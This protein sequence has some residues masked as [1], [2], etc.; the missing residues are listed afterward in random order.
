MSENYS[1]RSAMNGF[2]RNDVIIYIDGVLAEKARAEEKVA[3]LEKEL[4]SLR[5]ENE[6]L[7]K[8]ID[9]ENEKKSNNEK[10]SECDVSKVYEARLGA[11]MLDA[12]RFSEI[13]VKEANDKASGIFSNAYASADA[14]STKAKSIS[15][16]ISDINNQF[17]LAFKVLLDNMNSLG[18][19][20]DLFKREVQQTG[21]KFDFLTDFVPVE[22]D[23]HLKHTIETVVPQI[24]SSDVNF[25]DAD[26]FDIRVDIND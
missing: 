25:D 17:N 7:K 22:N 18:K 8:A 5:G 12:K 23:S 16:N 13:L 11:A 15:Q 26:E 9:E 2:N 6:A 21:S 4:E 24:G 10:C 20:L 1:F 14:T 19:S 3:A